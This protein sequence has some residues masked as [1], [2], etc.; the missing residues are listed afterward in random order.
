MPIK[1]IKKAKL[2]THEKLEKERQKRVKEIMAYVTCTKYGYVNNSA[3]TFKYKQK[4]MEA[5]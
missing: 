5:V 4:L 2:T 3:I 1:I